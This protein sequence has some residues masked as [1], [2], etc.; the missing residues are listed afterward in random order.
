MLS[1]LAVRELEVC[2]PIARPLKRKAPGTGRS[3]RAC[4][5]LLAAFRYLIISEVLP[6]LPSSL[7]HHSPSARA[8]NVAWD[9]FDVMRTQSP[10]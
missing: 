5:L 3:Y 10:P 2:Y 9:P 1:K 6:N 4:T 8:I 7:I